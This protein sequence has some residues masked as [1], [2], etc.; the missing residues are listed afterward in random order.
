MDELNYCRKDSSIIKEKHLFE[1]FIVYGLPKIQR[2]R[3]IRLHV[4][5]NILETCYQSSIST[6][7]P[8]ITFKSNYYN[9]F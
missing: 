3:S 7:K 6:Y 5:L 2:A 8:K 9:A 4:H 1:R